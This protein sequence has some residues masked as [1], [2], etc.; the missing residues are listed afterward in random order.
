MLSRLQITFGIQGTVLEWFRSYLSSRTQFVSI[1]SKKSTT[2]ELTVGIPQGSVMGPVLYLLYT[3]QLAEVI[4]SHGL[5]YHMYADDNQLYF[6]F[7]TQEVDL[8]KSKI[9]E[10]MASICN[11]MNLSELK[12]NHDKTEIMLFHSK[13]RAQPLIESLRVRYENVPLSSSARSLGVIF[14][15][16]MSFD[17]H[18]S[19][20]CKSSFYHLRNISKIRKYLNKESAATIVHAFVTSKLDYYLAKLDCC[21]AK[22]DCYL[23]KLDCYLAKLDCYLAKLD[24]YL[25]KLNCY[26]AKLDCYLAKLDC[27]LAKLDCYLAKLDYYLAELDCYLACLSIGH[28][29]CN[30]SRMLTPEWCAKDVNTIILHECYRNTIGYLPTLNLYS[31]FYSLY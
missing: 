25:A 11:W 5:D 19:Y 12:L 4:Q 16:T 26:L 30:M 13:F 27:Y 20:A 15:D 18:L 3:A 21:L 9:E 17:A 2:R 14:D 22:L 24:Y 29:G 8:A 6:S 7:K 1:N 28:G 10:C 23:A 31:R